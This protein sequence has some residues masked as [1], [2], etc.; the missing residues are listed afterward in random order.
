MPGWTNPEEVGGAGATVVVVVGAAVVVVVGLA[1]V[2]VVLLVVLVTVVIFLAG[3]AEVELGRQPASA[4]VVSSKLLSSRV[5]FLGRVMN[6]Y[7]RSP[8][9]HLR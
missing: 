7:R 3:S 6:P 9:G 8:D 5:G 4:T 2:L 1:V